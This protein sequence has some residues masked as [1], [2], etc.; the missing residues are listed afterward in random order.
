LVCSEGKHWAEQRKFTIRH[1]RELGFG[2]CSMEGLLQDEVQ[3][4]ISGLKYAITTHIHFRNID[5]LI[6]SACLSITEKKLDPQ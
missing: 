5:G 1:L 3:E 2:K 4:L 6:R